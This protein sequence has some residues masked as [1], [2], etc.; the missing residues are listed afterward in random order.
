MSETQVAY[1]TETVESQAFEISQ[2]AKTL[3]V[4]DEKTYLEAGEMLRTLKGMKNKVTDFFAPMKAKS[5]AA[6]KEICAKEN[7]A[8]RPLD[9]ADKFLRI[10]A[11]KYLDEQERIRKEAQ[12]KAEEE[13]RAAAEKEKQRLLDQAVKAEEKGKAEKAEALLEKAEM[14]YQ[15]PVVV[16]SVVQKTTRLETGSVTR[17]SDIQVIVSDQ[18]LFIK[19][20]AEKKVPITVVDLRLSAIKTWVKIN[21]IKDGEIPGLIIKEIQGI[22]IR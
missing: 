20:I 2:Q 12:R 14:V 21:D 8:V 9:D 18:F 10:E 4:L 3:K 16:P 5:Y 13:A 11:G 19:A 17:K 22:S 15:E 6:W 7:E 1:E